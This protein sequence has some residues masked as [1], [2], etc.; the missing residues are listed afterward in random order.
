MER[1]RCRSWIEQRPYAH[2]NAD[3]WRPHAHR[4]PAGS[5]TNADAADAGADAA[6]ASTSATATTTATGCTYLDQS[7]QPGCGRGRGP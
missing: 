3:G 6:T 5:L 7:D 4:H 2:R 1:W